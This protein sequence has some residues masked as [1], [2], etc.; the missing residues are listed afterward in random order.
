LF[1]HSV[2]PLPRS[3]VAGAP[4]RISV[5][6]W[7]KARKLLAPISL[8]GLCAA[9]ILSTLVG[10]DPWKPDE[11]YTF[12]LVV[13][14]LRR[15]DWVVPMLAG[16]PFLEKPP[17]FYITAAEFARV[18][19]GVLPLPDAA[20]LASG[21]YMAVALA[22]LALAARRLHRGRHG[23]TAVLILLGCLGMVVRAHQMIT[24]LALF[25]GISMGIYGL[26]AGRE[27]PI[28]GGFALGGGTAIAFLSKGLLGPGLLGLASLGLL[29][30][31]AWRRRTYLRSLTIAGMVALPG[32]AAWTCALYLRSV[33]YFKTWLIT[34]NLDRFLGQT[35]PELRQPHFY[36]AGM[37]LWYAFPAL[38]LAAWA[39]WDA[40]RRGRHAWNEAEIQLPAV[41]IAVMAVVLGAAADARDSYLM[42]VLL[43]M[44]L[45]AAAGIDRLPSPAGSAL[46]R[47]GKVAFGL[48]A[49]GLWLGWVALVTG[50][51]AA[52][53]R[54]LAEYQPGFA[55]RFTW[56]SFGLALFVTTSWLLAVW[57]RASTARRGITQ[58][59]A[60]V[61]L[62][63]GLVGT[64][65]LPYL[66]AGKSYRAMILSL[67]ESI[68]PENCIASRQLGEP[69]RALL[70]YYGR[71]RTVREEVSP[72]A[73][74]DALLVQGSRSSGASADGR[75]WKPIWEG[76]RPGDRNEIYRLYVRAGPAAPTIALARGRVV[77]G[78]GKPGQKG[79]N[80]D[81]AGNIKRIDRR[82]APGKRSQN[83]KLL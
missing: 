66:N 36:Y 81:V 29:A 56:L 9:W 15:G 38:P 52:L 59:T 71:I 69:Q 64:L 50:S 16:E 5:G 42:P 35:D 67:R 60:G 43:P 61:T 10:H 21:F 30:F 28:R 11:A 62:L 77:S 70:D 49:V 19:G 23:W 78:A 22:F 72:D 1:F 24:D 51:P 63:L 20:R 65:W 25:A 80:A 74:C 57:P 39:F 45:A 68:P 47:F 31:P 12:G 46:A 32:I 37:L 73:A 83:H 18:F 3:G 34:N 44:A 8:V 33:A 41:L 13:D 54:R 14:F 79:V 53:A 4:L 58:W 7:A 27:R 6:R 75:G 2:N 26:A 17:L 48:L 55:A 76:A 82:Y 40:A